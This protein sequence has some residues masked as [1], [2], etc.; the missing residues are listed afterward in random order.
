MRKRQVNLEIGTIIVFYSVVNE[1]GAKL[2]FIRGAILRSVPRICL[3]KLTS[4]H[5]LKHYL[6]CFTFGKSAKLP[7]RFCPLACIAS[8]ISVGINIDIFHMAMFSKASF[9]V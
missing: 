9:V 5:F 2:E 8:I 4:I 1:V 6:F 7:T 3:R